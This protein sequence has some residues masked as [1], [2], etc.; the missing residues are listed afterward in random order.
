MR[1]PRARR[2]AIA[3]AAFAI[4][5]TLT[6]CGSAQPSRSLVQPLSGDV[7]ESLAA[8]SCAGAMATSRDG[9]WSLACDAERMTKYA[10]GPAIVTE[11]HVKSATAVTNTM[12][13]AILVSLNDSGS[14]LF[15]DAT[16]SHVGDQLAIVVDQTVR[17]APFVQTAIP[18]GWL[19]I[20]G[21]FTEASAKKLAGQIKKTSL[22]VQQVLDQMPVT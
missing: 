10:L 6:A 16:A 9:S 7:K 18:G 1:S 22:S 3:L 17:S 15:A 8:F 12:N 13:W 14:Q 11:T 21:D 20:S 19:E 5:G 2:A 4:G